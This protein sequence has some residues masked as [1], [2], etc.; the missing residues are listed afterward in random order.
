[1][2]QVKRTNLTLSLE[3]LAKARQSLYWST[4]AAKNLK[5]WNKTENTTQK[6]KW[7]LLT[8][9]LK[10]NWCPENLEVFVKTLS[11]II[12]RILKY[13][14]S[15][16]W[17]R[18]KQKFISWE[19]QYYPILHNIILFYKIVGFEVYETLICYDPINCNNKCYI[20][21]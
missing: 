11:A 2:F 13:I 8:D 15:K 3:L 20:I 1:M 7:L 21:I 16:I 19:M 18:P 5:R 12:W 17:E 10:K 14:D 6:N 9:A 4:I